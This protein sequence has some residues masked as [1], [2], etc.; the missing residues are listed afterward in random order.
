MLLVRCNG[1]SGLAMT[2]WGVGDCNLVS[3]GAL[4]VDLALPDIRVG[5]WKGPES[6]EKDV[7]VGLTSCRGL[8]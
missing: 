8:L 1:A 7:E 5:C 3:T 2:T 6:I 4:D